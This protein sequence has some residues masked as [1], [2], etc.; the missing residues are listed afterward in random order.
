MEHHH[1]PFAT[2]DWSLIRHRTLSL[3]AAQ[4]RAIEALK[5]ELWITVEGHCGDLFVRNGETV[6]IP[7]RSGQVVIE[8]TSSTAMVRA[9]L[10]VQSPLVACVRPSF[11]DA[12][13]ASISQRM[14]ML[15]RT[16]A[17]ALRGLAL[18]IDPK[19]AC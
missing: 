3:D 15:L 10:A 6:D 17:T 16:V 4:V 7:R 14:A 8:A 9:A 12:A 1:Y 5:G 18:R 19:P 11:I 13:I 2:Q